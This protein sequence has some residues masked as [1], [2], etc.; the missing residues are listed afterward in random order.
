MQLMDRIRWKW[1]LRGR[2]DRIRM[3]HP[4]HKQALE[5]EKGTA[6]NFKS[7]NDT[8]HKKCKTLNNNF[9]NHVQ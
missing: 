5:G 7:L 2:K 6:S 3:N 1:N 8:S 9:V 4:Y